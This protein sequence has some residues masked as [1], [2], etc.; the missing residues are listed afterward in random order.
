MEPVKKQEEAEN[1]TA[2]EPVLI[3]AVEGKKDLDAKL[4]VSVIL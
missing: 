1:I 4:A 3:R 2:I